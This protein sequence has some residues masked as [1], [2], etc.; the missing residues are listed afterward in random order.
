MIR[1]ELIDASTG[2]MVGYTDS[3]VGALPESFAAETTL[4][5]G[6]QHWR[7]LHAEPM[8]R[9]EAVQTGRLVL[10]LQRMTA[11]MMSPKQVLYSLP[12]IFNP[13][14]G[15]MPGMSYDGK[16][17]FEL[18]EDDWRQ[19]EFVSSAQRGTIEIE[20]NE[21]RRIFLEHRVPPGFDAI[22]VRQA[23]EEPLRGLNLTRDQLQA[24]FPEAEAFSGLTYQ[25]ASG[26]VPTG[27]AFRYGV[28]VLYGTVEDG[29]VT[30][31]ALEFDPS[32]EPIS[33]EPFARLMN[34]YQLVL[35]DWVRAQTLT[36]S[37]ID[38]YL[39]QID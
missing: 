19:I 31:L 14:P 37:E 28:A 35:V 10:T 13:I 17:P 22:H 25:R 11:Q 15:V 7:V 33:A 26:L 36:A 34:D 39:R 6:G 18:D 9:E 38:A 27:F 8:S 1:V 29:R 2:Q 24:Y 21:I 16:P 3:E 32:G 23:P 5:I 4:Q 20:L 30:A 12:T